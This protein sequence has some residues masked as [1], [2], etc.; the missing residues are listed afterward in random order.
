MGAC[1]NAGAPEWK[2]PGT[3]YLKQVGGN[4]T[5]WSS[6][7]PSQ[8]FTDSSIHSPVIRHLL[9]SKPCAKLQGK[10]HKEDGLPAASDAQSGRGRRQAAN[11]ENNIKTRSVPRIRGGRNSAWGA[12]GETDFWWRGHRAES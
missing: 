12:G 3:L 1:I 9:Y 4:R 10:E 5:S 7:F 6:V 2:E 11:N 8:S